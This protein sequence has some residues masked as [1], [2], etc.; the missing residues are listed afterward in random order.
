[1]RGKM[2]QWDIWN[3]IPTIVTDE[4]FWGVNHCY[5]PV[6]NDPAEWFLNVKLCVFCPWWMWG[7]LKYCDM[8]LVLLF[9]FLGAESIFLRQI[10]LWV[11]PVKHVSLDT[12]TVP[13]KSNDHTQWPWQQV[14]NSKDIYIYIEWYRYN[15]GYRYNIWYIY[16]CSYMILYM[17][18]CT[19]HILIR[20]Q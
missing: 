2:W 15:I 9:Y 14:Q 17:Y 11:R 10:L 16:N 20:G 8:F 3:I 13:L 19:N 6:G 12:S 7:N 1:M 18:N 5:E 4:C